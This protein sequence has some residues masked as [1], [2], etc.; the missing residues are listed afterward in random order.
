M[1]KIDKILQ[2]LFSLQHGQMNH[3]LE[4]IEN[5][6]EKLNHPHK[7]YPVIHTA[8]T[9]GKGSVCCLI[10]SILQEN[11]LK[12]GLYTSPHIIEFNERIR[13]NG[14][15]I[16]NEEISNIYEKIEQNASEI[17]A[18]FFEITTAI[19]FEHFKNS[20]VDIAVIETG[21][22]GR[23]D[24]TNVV[25][26]ILSII[27]SID[28]DHCQIL[29]N[30]LE[31]IAQEK[32]GI[33]KQNS[34]VLVQDTNTKLF[35]I[36]QNV[37]QEKC[38]QLFSTYNFPAIKLNRYSDDLKMILD[39]E[40]PCKYSFFIHPENLV[41]MQ[42]TTN[43]VGSH[44]ISNIR[45]AIFAI[46]LISNNFT[47]GNSAIISGIKNITKN[48][49]YRFRIECV[50]SEPFVIID[51]AHNPQSISRLVRTLQEMNSDS[52]KKWNFIFGAM[53]DKDIFE[54]LKF[55]KP[56]CNKL[57]ITVP[58]VERAATVE[59]IKNIANELDFAEI[60]CAES[61]ASAVENITE[62]T[63]ICGS[64]YVIEEAVQSLN[65]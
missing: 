43:F 32:A 19:A 31:E 44:Q 3:G 9:N 21:L 61:V 51:V 20:N 10:A 63:V 14:T 29:G 65:I 12:V 56:I 40:L 28:K 45:T 53:L 17:G 6:V 64:F 52:S 59:Q 41:K 23:L 13:V 30:S 57:I 22:G 38:T 33:I 54:M 7:K 18:S 5:L 50:C 11:G 46:L 62:D 26:P 8:G 15:K 4:R 36:W 42:I 49:G 25:E 1:E 58:K 48:T 27:T 2:Y 24:S 34:Q 39:L 60:I 16:S 37:A 35:E 55:I 47:V